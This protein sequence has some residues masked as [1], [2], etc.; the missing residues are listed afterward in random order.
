MSYFNIIKLDATPSSNDWLKDRFV[1][2]IV[3]MEMW[4]GLEIKPK[5]GQRKS[6]GKQ[7]P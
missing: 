1:S 2:E 6:F 3:Q 7:N 5:E 4:C